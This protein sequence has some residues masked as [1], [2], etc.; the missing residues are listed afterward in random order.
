MDHKY[1]LVDE[2]GCPI[3]QPFHNSNILF[4]QCFWNTSLLVLSCEQMKN[5]FLVGCT[6]VGPGDLVEICGIFLP[7]PYTGFRAMRA[8][9]V[10][11]TYLQAM[12][13]TQTKKRYDEYV[14]CKA[15]IF[16][17]YLLSIS[18]SDPST[19]WPADLR[20]FSIQI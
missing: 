2:M 14:S 6:Q 18:S 15:Y 9:L 1:H 17:H 4:Y 3:F 7:T 12:S 11:D 16:Y 10:A 20:I 5:F 8:G 13:I 19:K